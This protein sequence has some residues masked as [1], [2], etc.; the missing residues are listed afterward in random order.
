MRTPKNTK[1]AYAAED[2]AT[3]LYL[4]LEGT[5]PRLTPLTE[6]SRFPD[7]LSASARLAAA[8]GAGGYEVVRVVS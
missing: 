3:G 8:V 2:A 7:R 6:A 1:P 5:E 4:N